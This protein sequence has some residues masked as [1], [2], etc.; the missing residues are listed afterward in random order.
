M[1][2]NTSDSDSSDLS[3]V[4]T[5]EAT[6]GDLYIYDDGAKDWV[7]LDA[8]AIGS[9][10]EVTKQQIDSQ[11]LKFVPESNEIKYLCQRCIRQRVTSQP[12]YAEFAYHGTD[13][14][15]TSSSV[16]MSIDVTPDTDPA[17]LTVETPTADLNEGFKLE[18]WQNLSFQGNSGNGVSPDTVEERVE[19]A[20]EPD[21][22]ATV[23]SPDFGTQ[24]SPSITN[25]TSKLTGLVF[26]EAGKSYCIYR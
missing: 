3:I 16:T 5:S 9:G 17:Q 18:Q 13:G 8:Q 11:H 12:D 21:S 25:I 26:L 20:G 24:H 23:Q 6:H 1:Q 15:N 19:S 4:I 7:K 2:F 14:V 10:Y 22:S